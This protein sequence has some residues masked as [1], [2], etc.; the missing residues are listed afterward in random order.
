MSFIKMPDPGNP[1]EGMKLFNLTAFATRLARLPE[2]GHRQ[3]NPQIMVA[4]NRGA[5]L[6][7]KTGE[8]YH[9]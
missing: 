2:T 9:S 8:R 3:A 4:N 5:S 7:K 6:F 1:N